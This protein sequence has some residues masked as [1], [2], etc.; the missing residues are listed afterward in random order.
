MDWLKD[1]IGSGV[2]ATDLSTAQVCLRAVIVFFAALIIVR[3]A[4]KRFFAR[5]N[6][7]DVILGFVLAS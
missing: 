4:D 5:K 1:A 6:A 3:F 7:F 2:Q